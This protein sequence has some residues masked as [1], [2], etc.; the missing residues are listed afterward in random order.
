[1]PSRILTVDD[2]KTVRIIVRKA[3]R[4]FDC[5]I[6]EAANGVE[7][8]AAAAA[9]RP[10]LII[11][12]I[13]MP[14][15]DGVEM[16][17][18]LKADPALK[19][20][21]VM[22]LTAEGGREHVL[23]IAKLGIRDYIVKPFKEDTLVEK[24]GRIIPLKQT[25]EIQAKPR[26]IVDPADI[27][28]VDDKPAIVSQIRDGL[29]HTKWTIHSAVSQA[30]ALEYCAK[31]TP[32]LMIVSLSLPDDSAFALYRSVRNNPKSK[33]TPFFGLTV[34]TETAM[35]HAAQQVGIT[36]VITKPIDLI[37]LESKMA[38]ALNLDT[39]LRYFEIQG[40]SII[41]RLPEACLPAVLTDVGHYM[42]A[43]LPEA[44]DGGINQAIIDVHL[45]TGVDMGIIRLLM[46]TTQTCRELGMNYAM[47]GN[48]RL[49][50]ACREFE[51]TKEWTF[52]ETTDAAREH[53]ARVAAAA[54][55]RAGFQLA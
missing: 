17:M 50:E 12:D 4:A 44:V 25:S 46:Q 21:P 3:F 30:E 55:S 37:E 27:L 49:T 14:V 1:M 20:I 45:L 41:M 10:D 22:M 18:K 35:Q 33:G 47:V 24:V 52:C 26:S 2:S 7:G 19:P 38:K 11:L 53:L 39:S 34:K 43:K 31:Q 23:R 51:D 28:V 54:G 36:A 29:K 40:D 32:D 6:I 13:T 9:S 48:P 8:L 5:E 15:M 42:K 16:L